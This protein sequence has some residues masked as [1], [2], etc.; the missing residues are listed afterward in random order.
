MV[1]EDVHWIRRPGEGWQAA[2]AQLKQASCTLFVPSGA[3]T[4]YL[5]FEPQL[6]VCDENA[7]TSCREPSPWRVSPD[8][9]S[10]WPMLV[11]S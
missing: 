5:F 10:A 8:Q 7:L 6:R 4:M 9:P 2:A 1:Y 11:K 3:R